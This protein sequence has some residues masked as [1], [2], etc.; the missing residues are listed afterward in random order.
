MSD[1][2]ESAAC[3]GMDPNW[4]HP[5]RGGDALK[6]KAICATCPVTAECLAD[7]GPLDMGIRAGVSLDMH[8]RRQATA[9]LPKTG[10]QANGGKFLPIA[11][12]TN[13]GYQQERHRGLEPCRD[14]MDA[15]NAYRR[16]LRAAA[17]GRAA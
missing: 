6:A 17:K 2:T 5:P 3:R 7:A 4:W 15:K 16:A 8:R 12:G 10:R 11:H 14:C 9:H 1:W 13:S